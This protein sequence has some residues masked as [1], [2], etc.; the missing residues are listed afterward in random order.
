MYN[1]DPSN[2]YIF[3][4]FNGVFVIEDKDMFYIH[5]VGSI[6]VPTTTKINIFEKIKHV[7][8]CEK[9]SLYIAVTGNVYLHHNKNVQFININI[10]VKEIMPDFNAKPIKLLVSNIVHA[11]VGEPNMYTLLDNKGE[12][13]FNTDDDVVKPHPIK[14]IKRKLDRKNERAIAVYTVACVDE[15]H[16]PFIVTDKDNVYAYLY[17]NYRSNI[18][19]QPKN[20]NFDGTKII[21]VLCGLQHTIFVCSTKTILYGSN[22]KKQF[23]IFNPDAKNGKLGLQKER[24]FFVLD[25]LDKNIRFVANHNYTLKINGQNAL[26]SGCSGK[27]LAGFTRFQ[28]SLPE[29]IYDI[30]EVA[31]GYHLFFIMRGDG[32]LYGY[33]NLLAPKLLRK[34]R[35][36]K[37]VENKLYRNVNYYDVIVIH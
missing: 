17:P 16:E 22:L 10:G 12:L 11:C 33:S 27:S 34:V 19:K 1:I 20:I 30:Q 3:P 28:I 8:C 18:L 6:S 15:P 23:E 35:I 21:K 25:P 9:F 14:T 13:Y 29:G 26:L 4:S 7:L 31:A 32:R 5:Y 24:V 36:K 2:N 37:S